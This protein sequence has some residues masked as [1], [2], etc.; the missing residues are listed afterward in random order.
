[1]YSDKLEKLIA[2]ALADDILTDKAKQALMN[3][4][5]VEGVDLD[6]FETVLEERLY[7]RPRNLNKTKPSVPPKSNTPV[8]STEPERIKQLST[9]VEIKEAL[10]LVS[11]NSD[12]VRAHVIK[13]QLQVI[14]FVE[15]PQLFDSVFDLLI[16]HLESAIDATQDEQIKKDVQ[17]KGAIMAN[18]MLFLLQAKLY[19]VKDQHSQEARKLMEKACDLLADNANGLLSAGNGNID[20]VR[21]SADKLFNNI[22]TDKDDEK[23]FLSGIG[24][25]YSKSNKLEEKEDAFYS[26]IDNIIGKLSRNQSIFGKSRILAELVLRFKDILTDR[27]DTLP[28]KGKR[29]RT[30]SIFAGIANVIM[31]LVYIVSLFFRGGDSLINATGLA[32]TGQNHWYN[33]TGIWLKYTFWG[34]IICILLAWTIDW[35]IY[36]IKTDQYRKRIA[37][38]DKHYSD[39]ADLFS[40]NNKQ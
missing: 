11:E 18:S 33:D 17:K 15:H 2:R 40:N 29:R 20:G 6:E 12:T 32:D 14:E 16:D 3:A 38:W 21:V 1:M 37:S 35:I 24:N 5:K 27:H 28:K 19:Y 30:A 8:Q 22:I 9:A 26:L 23:S 25:W 7:K 31:L 13:A 36:K 10:T 34:S 4:A 39:I